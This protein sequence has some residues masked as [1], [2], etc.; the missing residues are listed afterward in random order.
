MYICVLQFAKN[1]NQMKKSYMKW[2]IVAVIA[3]VAYKYWD[4]ISALWK[5]P[6]EMAKAVEEEGD[7][8]DS[9]TA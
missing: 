2:L 5:K 7:L 4:K 8:N 9:T 1:T 6:D 3:F